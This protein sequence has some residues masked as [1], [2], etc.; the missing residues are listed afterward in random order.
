M[1]F[2]NMAVQSRK[3]IAANRL[4]HVI[5]VIQAKVE[6]VKEL[7]DGIEKAR[8]DQNSKN[9]SFDTTFGNLHTN[10]YKF[11]SLYQFEYHFW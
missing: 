7:P 4:D 3:I 6:D 8:K 1:E 9:G 2:S 10:W 5:T 11:W